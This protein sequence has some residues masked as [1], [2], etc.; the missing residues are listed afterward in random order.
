MAKRIIFV[1]DEPSIR[2]IYEMLQPF[3]GNGYSVTTAPGGEEALAFMKVAFMKDCSFDVIVSDLTMPRMTG[4]QLLSEVSQRYPSTARIVVSG[5]ADE[6]TSAKCL[7]VGHRYFTKPF[8]PTALTEVIISLCDARTFAANDRIREYV[9]KIEAIPTLSE[10]Y[11][12]LTKALRSPTLPIRDI[13]TIIEN[14]LALTAKVLQTV[15]SVRFAPSRRVQSVFEAVQLIGFE[16]VRALV[17]SIQVFEFCHKT[18]K[19]ELFQT[20]WSHSL[21]TAIRAKR[22]AE[23]ED[24]PQEACDETFLLGLLHDI[25]KVVLGASCPEQYYALWAKNRS[26]SSALIDAESELF[27]ADHAHVG[28]F[29]LRLWGLPEALASGVQMHH[30]ISSTETLG[31]SPLVALHV[32]QELAPNRAHSRLDENLIAQLGLTERVPLWRSIV[33]R[34]NSPIPTNPAF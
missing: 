9:G 14:D 21:R 28:A 26:N 6:I 2:G 30:A 8:D 18:A 1:D 12:E 4:I 20:I 5:F 7:M 34:E 24:L 25:G 3:F 16:V 33:H 29:L 15:N 32:A 13:A 19:T 11:I 22:L 17:L 31:F 27:G 10:T 23:F